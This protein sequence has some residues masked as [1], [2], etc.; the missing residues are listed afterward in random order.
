LA[1]RDDAQAYDGHG[2][3]ARQ[4]SHEALR[5]RARE[6][7]DG[8]QRGQVKA[9][10]DDNVLSRHAILAQPPNEKVHRRGASPMDEG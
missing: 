5:R 2:R 6:V 9:G 3:S 8:E 7:G 10:H 1:E 4:G